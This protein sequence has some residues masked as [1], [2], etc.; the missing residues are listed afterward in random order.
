MNRPRVGVSA[1]LLGQAV[2]YDGQSKPH[3]WICEQ[4]AQ[5][6]EL[7]PYC[8]EVG[9]ELGVPRTAVHLVK[10]GAGVRALA[11]DD[12]TLDVTEAIQQWSE[13][14]GPELAL[15]DALILKSRSPSC[16]VGLVPLFDS[17]G[18]LLSFGDGL[19]A[20][21]VKQHNSHLLLMEEASLDEP[22]ARSW[23]CRQL[24]VQSAGFSSG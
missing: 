14:N 20:A 10:T 11:V 9:A 19:F 15:L 5:L 13:E 6:V 2:R 22:A 4:L 7:V 8:P 3:A 1:C 12:A 18:G 21:W 23:L 24:G 16:G 17:K